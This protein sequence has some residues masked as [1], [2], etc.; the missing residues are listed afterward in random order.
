MH[1]YMPFMIGH[2]GTG[3]SPPAGAGSEGVEE[4]SLRL[5]SVVV[6]VIPTVVCI[7]YLEDVQK[8]IFM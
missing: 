4:V 3:A 8:K 2:M 5:S 7:R 6:G 1:F